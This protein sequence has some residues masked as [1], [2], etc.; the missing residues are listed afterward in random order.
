MNVA[1]A[2][3]QLS[4]RPDQELV[5]R[6]KLPFTAGIGCRRK[7]RETLSAIKDSAQP[8]ETIEVDEHKGIFETDFAITLTNCPVGKVKNVIRALNQFA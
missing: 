7:V 4:I 5:P 8:G 3:N 6:A 1:T 2:L